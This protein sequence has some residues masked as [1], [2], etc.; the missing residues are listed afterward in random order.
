MRRTPKLQKYGQTMK[1]ITKSITIINFKDSVTHIKL[2]D[3]K[4]SSTTVLLHVHHYQQFQADLG[5][6]MKIIPFDV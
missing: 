3:A 2:V 5:K 1:S 4:D 6:M